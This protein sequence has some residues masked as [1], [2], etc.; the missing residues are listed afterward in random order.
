MGSGIEKGNVDRNAFSPAIT[1]RTNPLLSNPF[2]LISYGAI[3][4]TDWVMPEKSETR[5]IATL[6]IPLLFLD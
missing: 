4:I 5:L 2:T 6:D 3:A 1:R